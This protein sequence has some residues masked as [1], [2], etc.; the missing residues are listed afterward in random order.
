MTTRTTRRCWTLADKLKAAL[1]ASRTAVDARFAS[2]H[3]LLGQIG[4]IVAPR[5]D[6][7]VGT[8][9]SMHQLTGMEKV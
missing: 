2:T 1:G 8:S 5:L 4:K 9:G 6:V 7:G 3:C